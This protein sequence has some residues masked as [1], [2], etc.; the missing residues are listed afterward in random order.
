MNNNQ[1]F[2]QKFTPRENFLMSLV[3]K[4]TNEYKKLLN[5]IHM[6]P[7]KIVD[8]LSLSPIPGESKF[9][10]QIAHKNCVLHLSAADI[11]Q[12]NYDL[13]DFSSFHAEMIRKGGEG[14][15]IEFLKLSEIEPAYRIEGKRFDVALQQYL[16]T[17]ESK[18]GIQFKKT[19]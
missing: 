4:L 18:E 12:K 14:K 19:A 2:F 3:N 8:I 7:Y 16:F 9:T 15:L 10:I 13:N 1:D 11:L 6:K 5:H 17:I